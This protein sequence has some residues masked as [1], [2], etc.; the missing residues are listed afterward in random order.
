MSVK[1][2]SP[3]G[4]LPPCFSVSW[5]IQFPP[6]LDCSTVTQI[7]DQSERGIRADWPIRSRDSV[8][9]FYH[10]ILEI[11]QLPPSSWSM[12]NMF[13]C[14]N[15]TSKGLSNASRVK[16][17]IFCLPDHPKSLRKAIFFWNFIKPSQYFRLFFQILHFEWSMGSNNPPIAN[18]N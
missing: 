13:Q 17:G 3:T 14:F 11:F 7:L 6:T 2:V 15:P 9:W 8:S 12:I 5:F 18:K 16:G 4:F 1:S 10:V